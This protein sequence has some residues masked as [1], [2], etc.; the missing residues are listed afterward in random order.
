MPPAGPAA[1]PVPAGAAPW[2]RS[3]RRTA[4][5]SLGA[6]PGRVLPDHSAAHANADAHGGQAVADLR[7]LGELARELGHQPYARGGERVADRDG[8]AP[9]VDP[10]VVVGD[11]EVVEEREHLHGERLVQLE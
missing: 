5:R 1:V 10:W 6:L 4:V 8:A 11:A 2:S 3:R 7:M 9:R